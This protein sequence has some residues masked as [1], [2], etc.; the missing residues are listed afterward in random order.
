MNE[1]PDLVP[2]A[3]DN[4]RNPD[5]P[6]DT[7]DSSAEPAGPGDLMS[8]VEPDAAPAPDE[9]QEADDPAVPEGTPEAEGDSHPEELS[10]ADAGDAEAANAVDD[11]EYPGD[12]APTAPAEQAPADDLT[13]LM[14]GTIARRYSST[15]R[16][17]SGLECRNLSR[18]EAILDPSRRRGSPGVGA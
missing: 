9:S 10:A 3:D 11:A 8:P 4:A 6:S 5:V 2:A 16:S 17:V 13:D 1:T 18:T 7:D 12:A 14:P 15:R